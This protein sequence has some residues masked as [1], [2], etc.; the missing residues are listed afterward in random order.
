VLIGSMTGGAELSGTITAI[1]PPR[2]QR[3]GVA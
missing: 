3:L 2:P 1:W